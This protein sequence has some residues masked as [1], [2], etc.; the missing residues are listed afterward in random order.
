MATIEK[1]HQTLMWTRGI[2]LKVISTE[3]SDG[4]IQGTRHQSGFDVDVIG[5]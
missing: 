1:F 5:L 2:C 4:G 3:M